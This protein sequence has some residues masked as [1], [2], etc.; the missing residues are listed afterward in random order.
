MPPEQGQQAC[1]HIQE[2]KYTLLLAEVN[3]GVHL[4][5]WGFT[6][7]QVASPEQGAYFCMSAVAITPD[8]GLTLPAVGNL[9]RNSGSS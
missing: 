1:D 6:F 5:Q 9:P 8:N 3:P 2:S 4:P 7:S